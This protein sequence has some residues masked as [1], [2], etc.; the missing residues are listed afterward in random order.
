MYG[1]TNK[2]YRGG[3]DGM[4]MIGQGGLW[5]PDATGEVSAKIRGRSAVGFLTERSIGGG[6]R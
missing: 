3:G 4:G 5:S 6:V 2:V 1:C